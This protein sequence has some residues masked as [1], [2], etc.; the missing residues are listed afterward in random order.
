MKDQCIRQRHAC[1]LATACGLLLLVGARALAQG[2]VGPGPGPAAAP[3]DQNKFGQAPEDTMTQF[4]REQSILLKQGE[5]QF[6]IGLN[7]TM[8]DQHFT[9]LAVS[10]GTVTA[11]NAQDRRRLLIMPLDIRYGLTDRL[12]AFADLPVGWANTEISYIGDESFLNTGGLGDL[13][14]GVSYLLH[15]SCGQSCDPDVI[16]TFGFTAP[17]G[18]GN[19]FASIFETPETTLGQG[20]WA[21]YW[22][23]LFVHTYDPI[24]I[25]YGFGTRHPFAREFDGVDT[26]PGAQYNYRLGV[27]FAVNEH[28]TLSTQLYGAYISEPYINGVRLQGDILEPIYLRFACTTVNCHRICEPFVEIGLT[29]DAANTRFG[30]TWTY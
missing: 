21:A 4:L 23:V 5:C 16:A 12:Q 28:V 3:A 29:P 7:Y 19:F 8:V 10:G 2:P 6:D 11:L 27:G 18:N 14:A 24:I 22:N 9:E 15:K 25:F 30:I 1:W 26:A 20:L 13:N 17:T